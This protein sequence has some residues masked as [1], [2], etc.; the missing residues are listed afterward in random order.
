MA[1]NKKNNN[2]VTEKTTVTK[3]KARKAKTNKKVKEVVKQVLL[4]TLSVVLV[5]GAIVGCWFLLKS[6][7]KAPSIE[8]KHP[9]ELTPTDTVEIKIK[10]YN[11]VIEIDLYGEQAPKTVEYLTQIFNKFVDGEFSIGSNAISIDYDGDSAKKDSINGEFFLNGVTSNNIKH[12]PG[13][14]TMGKDGRYNTDASLINILFEDSGHSH[15]DGEEHD[16]GMDGLYA[17]VG[18]IK[19][20]KDLEFLVSLVDAYKASTS[21][22]ETEP[23]K[24]I[25]FG[26]TDITVDDSLVET[27][28]KE[29]TNDKNETVKKEVVVEGQTFDRTFTPKTT[30]TYKFFSEKFKSIAIKLG[31]EVLTATSGT[32]LNSTVEYELVAGREYTITIDASGL[33]VGKYS[34]TISGN[35]L[36]VG[37]GN[38]VD[39]AP[40]P[41]SVA[42][43][44]TVKADGKYKFV[45]ADTKLTKLVIKLDGQDLV[46]V[47]GDT[48]KD[49]IEYELSTGKEYTVIV[50]NSTVKP[51]DYATTITEGEFSISDDKKVTLPAVKREV[52]YQFTAPSSSTYIF[53]SNDGKISEIVVLDGGKVVN[54]ATEKLEAGKTYDVQMITKDTTKDSTTVAIVEKTLYA[55]KTNKVTITS[56]D[57]SET[58]K[59]TEYLF[60]PEKTGRHEFK[61]TKAGSTTVVADVEIEIFDKDGKSMGKGTAFL[62]NDQVYTV[63]I[64]TE[65]LTVDTTYDVKITEPV[66]LDGTTN[67]IVITKEESGKDK[68]DKATSG[69]NYADYYF[70][71]TYDGKYVITSGDT[72]FGIEIWGVVDGQMAKISEKD[73]ATVAAATLKKDM[74]YRV[75][76]VGLEVKGETNKLVQDKEYKITVQNPVLKEGNN[77]LHLTEATETFTFKFSATALFSITGDNVLVE[78]AKIV[79]LDEKG[80]KITDDKDA[81]KYIILDEGKT[82]QVKVEREIKEGED[83]NFDCTISINKALPVI[84]KVEVK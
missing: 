5:A 17:A 64:K 41:K 3:E 37:S 58:V 76:L 35:I 67:T 81:L 36:T 16:Y 53:K 52:I 1:N 60:A 19:D 11:E 54:L 57:K 10:G 77:V 15:E 43:K 31:D 75:K 49:G 51:E 27:E 6:C 38:A 46:K 12:V 23:S 63:K 26:K 84:E 66:L 14:I 39:F 82:Y 33:E 65:K 40:V 34:L 59:Y 8:Y 70:V 29:T 79:L 44:L 78:K 71:P 25:F 20:H 4:I 13:V 2:Y 21:K 74:Q 68:D 22:T 9:S 55:D 7:S 42:Y 61:I 62:S 73:T 32:S 48:L 80:E 69:Q 83:A 56:A 24:E 30:G 50:S 18:Y 45:S 72:D 47:S 28:E